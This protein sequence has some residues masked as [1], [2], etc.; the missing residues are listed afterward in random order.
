MKLTLT[1]QSGRLAGHSYELESGYMTIGR[2]ENCT[3]RFDPT[4]ERI[5]SKQHAFIE[6]RPDGFYIT[7]NNSTNGTI[8]NGSRVST[9][10]LNSGDTIQFGRNGATGTVAIEEPTSV[11]TINRDAN[12]DFERIAAAASAPD[13]LQNSFANLGMGNVQ[14]AVKPESPSSGKQ[15]VLYLLLAA[16]IMTMVFL[17][18]VVAGIMILSLGPV[19]ALIATFVAFL[20]AMLYVLPLMWLDRYD[21]EPLWLLAL[22]FAWGAIVSIFFS[23]IINTT[24]AEVATQNWSAGAGVFVGAVISAPIFEESS[25]GIGL[26]LLLI[27]FRRYFDDVLDGIVFGGVIA[28]GF[29]TVENVLYYGENLI[30][31]GIGGLILVFILRGILSPFAHVF[32]TSMTG[33]GCGIARETHKTYLKIIAPIIGYLAAVGL[34]MLWNFLA[35]M[36][37]FIVLE[38]D[39]LWAC[40]YVPVLSS[41]E[42]QSDADMCA[43]GL[44]YSLLQIPL[45]LIFVAFTLWMMRR[46]NRILKEMLAIDVARG[47]IY[48]EHEKIVRS[49]FRSTF[50]RLGGIF[51]GKYNDRRRYLR[52]LGKLGLSYWHI[53]RA[54]AAQGQ[55]GSFQQNP[56]LRDE[57]LQLRDRV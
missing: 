3:V 56:L 24:L 40:S 32:F 29:A 39:L 19:A 52:A 18:V 9:V 20:P 51:S 1:V 50:W 48:P 16:S 33:I 54:T 11:P 46:Q 37:R 28:L 35:V 57:V 4:L 30:R 14:A 41:T 26:L 2:S 6:A 43:F 27:A 38:M 53:Q 45:F 44:S 10:R 31:G 34:H 36:G 5:A 42:L 12:R 49:A 22:A 13:N 8:V 47:L 55:T 17:A 21:P 15:V 25:K 7:D 23:L